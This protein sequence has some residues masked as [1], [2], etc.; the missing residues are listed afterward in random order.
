[1]IGR[2]PIQ[3][4]HPTVDCGRYP[5]KAAAGETFEIAATVFREGH[6]AVAAG[7]VLTGPD[8]VRGPLLRMRELA[9]GTDRWGVEVTLPTEGDWHF[10]VE[11]WSDPMATWLHDAGIKIPRDMDAELMCE[12]GARL[13]ERAAKAVRPADCGGLSRGPAAVKAPGGKTAGGKTVGKAAGTAPAGSAEREAAAEAHV[14]GHR[15]ALLSVAA[16][17]RD[18]DLDPRARFSLAQLPETAELLRAHP[19][20]DLVT[21]SPRRVVRVDRRRALFGSWYEFFPRSEGAIVERDT[22]P[23]SGN[24]MTSAKRLPAVAKM[25]FDVVYLPPI[26]PIGHSFRKG[27]NNTLT[28]EPYDPG[29]PW[30]IGSEE[31]GHDAIHPDLGTFEDFDAFVAKTRELGMEVALDLAL[32]CAPDHPWVKEHPEWFNIRADG[33]IAYAENP[34]KK[35]QDIYPLNFDKD[36]EGI[37]AEVKRVVRVWMDHGVRIFRVDNPHTKPVAFWERLLADIN[38]TDPDVLFLAEAFTRPAMMQALAKVGFHQSY[39]YFTWKNSRP[40]VE[41]Y[42]SELSHETSHFLRPN[43]FVNTPDILHEYLQQGGVPAFY[44]RA[45]LA[46]TAMPTWGVYAGY[47]LA[48]NVPVRPGSEEYL[49]SEKYQYKPRDWVEAEREGRSLAPFITQLNLFRRAHPALQE[50]RNLRFHSVDHPDVV[51]FSKRLPGAYDTATRRHGLGD[52]VLTVVNLDPHNTHE[53]TVSLDM[54]SLGLDWHAE[55]FVDDELSG[56]S[57]R[58]RQNNYVRLDPHIHPAHI[59]TLRAATANQR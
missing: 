25:G 33:S 27:R 8:G 2:I 58:W 15:A 46:A 31:G 29:S 50:L 48:E 51:C 13:F 44:I 35:Y 23:K 22:A 3:D 11:A 17:L 37:Y 49:D 14:C 19:L 26:H 16:K 59:F 38:S 20:R 28:P 32:Q 34:P 12:E 5:A 18:E 7:A 56:E 42:L 36:P 9:P 54:P 52:V 4:I 47:E 39:T 21:R 55:F 6:D 10:R 57:Y 53:A 45:I 30:A 41:A 40:E 1:M 43:V 24:F